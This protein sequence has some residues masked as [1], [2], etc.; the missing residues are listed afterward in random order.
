[1]LWGKRGLLK[2][3]YFSDDGRIGDGLSNGGDLILWRTP[4]DSSVVSTWRYEGSLAGVSWV[5]DGF[6]G[7]VQHNEPPAVDG[8]SPGIERNVLVGLNTQIETPRLTVGDSTKVIVTGNLSNGTEVNF[9]TT[10]AWQID[11][12]RVT[13]QS[14]VLTARSEG[15]AHIQPT[16]GGVLGETVEVLVAPALVE[17][18]EVDGGGLESSGRED[19]EEM[20]PLNDS[21]SDATGLQ[22]EPNTS[23]NHAPKFRAQPD[24][25]AVSGLK[26]IYTPDV[27]D[28][29]GDPVQLSGVQVPSWLH[30][31]EGR[32]EGRAP[33]GAG[34]MDRFS[35]SASDGQD[36]TVQTADLRV[37]DFAEI[38]AQLTQA[39]LF[40]EAEYSIALAFSEQYE[41]QI[42]GN[43]E[44][45]R[46]NNTLIL[47]TDGE[48]SF[49]MGIALSSH[50]ESVVKGFEI[51]VIQRPDLT[52]TGAVLV[53]Q[54][55]HNGDGD[56]DLL[57][58]QMLFVQNTGQ[59]D[60]DLSGWHIGE[61]GKKDVQIPEGIVLQKGELMRVFGFKSP[62]LGLHNVSAGG[63]IGDGL[64]PGDVVVLVTANRRDTLV[65]E[66]LPDFPDGK[67]IQKLDGEWSTELVFEDLEQGETRRQVAVGEVGSISDTT[68]TVGGE[69][70]QVPVF[71]PRPNPFNS[72]TE[73]GFY[74]EGGATEVTVYSVLGQPVRQLVNRA[75]SVGYYS[76]IWDGRDNAGNPVGTG[77]YLIHFQI[78]L[79][80]Y[81][82]RVALLR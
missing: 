46:Q 61:I 6:G 82:H 31:S 81:T 70:L 2:P 39:P 41:L 80:T 76:R 49:P 16:W 17:P 42:D 25:V 19:L 9:S 12:G 52:L 24:S 62:P 32:F 43:W 22:N 67:L 13:I 77:V 34:N 29:D 47:K 53:P 74:S 14:G 35:V 15:V 7:W 78:G 5:N 79:S 3:G 28:P 40:E 55:D 4:L 11:S 58:D 23:K 50:K 8:F 27:F 51:E 33:I 68:T 63:R 18:N 57:A 65:L 72:H 38:A 48:G 45:R 59:S 54:A 1:V 37:I 60:V 71:A 56:A 21:G 44:W 69:P 73:F 75:L 36:A 26:Y 20:S 30:Y 66:R 64:G 10:V